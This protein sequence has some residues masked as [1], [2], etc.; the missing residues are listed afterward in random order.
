M[1]SVTFGVLTISDTCWREPAKDTSGPV[2][3]QL[4]VETFANTQ[5]IGNIVPDEKDLIQQ[6]LRKWI[7]REELRVILTT[8]GTGFAPRDVTPEATKQLLEKECPQLSMFITLE[9]IKQ[10]QY[11]ALSRGLCGIAGNTL[12]LNLPGSE[13]AV[14]ECFQTIRELLPHAVHLIGNDVSLVR[15]THEEVQGSAPKGHICPNKTGTGTDSDRNSPYPML[16][17]KEVLS[18][19][20]NT[21]QKTTNLN[22]I[23]L[24]M[25]APVNIPPFRASIKDGYAMKSTGFSGSKR[26]LGCIAAGDSPNSLPL[27]EDECYKINTGA[28]LPLEADCVVQVE[29]TKLLQLDKNGQ[30]CL[31]DIMLEPQAGLDVRP[32]GYDLSTNDHIF[33]AL[34]PSPVVVKSLL[35]S[36]G[37]KLVIPN[38]RVA[39]VSTGSELLSPRDQ[40]TPGKIFD[41]NTTMLTELLVYFGYNCMHT[42]VLCDSFEQTK[43][44]LLD[45]FEVVDFVICSGGVSMGDKDF[46]KSVLEDLQFKIHCGRV[47]IKPGKPMTFASRNDKYFFG[48]PGNPVSAFVTFHLF[49]LPAIRF[50]AGWD[51]CKC[52]L[53][54]LNVKLLNDFSLDSRPEF[55]R[56]S[57]ISKSGE[58][59]ASVNGNQISSRLQSIVG[60]DVLIHLPARTTDRPLAKA[61][62]VFPAS[63]L[64]FDFISKYE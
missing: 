8:G 6:E 56:A 13:K 7:N 26:V 29:D 18:I 60:A 32:V 21:V 27:A 35:A 52:S 1:E 64:R 16:A 54:V 61:G 48:L 12:I 10:T 19:I 38:P 37:N 33:P 40:L 11:A 31:V 5:V 57:V 46:I 42:S 43:E 47:N 45:I 49:A 34:D 30:E 28:P 14:K 20:F 2:L 36:V 62:E 59:Y 9:S 17:V 25:K 4:I 50:A 15:K 39:I 58:L 51:R 22:K 24:E 53:S 41:S 55:V 3:R 44:S 63:V 23:L